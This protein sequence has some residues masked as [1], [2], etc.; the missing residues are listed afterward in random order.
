M[1][2][3]GRKVGMVAAALLG[4]AGAAGLAGATLAGAAPT[5]WNTTVVR[6]DGAHMIG[7]PK[8]KRVLTEF[9]SYTC[10]H[11]G[12]FARTGDE[13]LKLAHVGPGKMRL[14]IRHIVRDPVD[15][16]AAMLAWCGPAAKF[17]RN[18]AALMH[19]QPRWLAQA[20]A[21]TPA[22]RAR[23]ASGDLP[24]RT[25]AIAS[26]LDFYPIM[27]ARG[28]NRAAADRCLSD[29]AMAKALAEN[30]DRDA[31]RFNVAGT[32]S[33]MLDGKLLPKVHSWPALEMALKGDT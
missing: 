27:E 26:D 21:T 13:A 17:P 24:T 33:F 16:T 11:C 28:V 1:K 6:A 15:L 14:E 8:A 10:P 2:I 30:S 23:W 5:N 12:D 18:H 31:E 4:A 32:P 3:A 20:R 9:V 29:A 7:N 22:Q 25:R 19:A